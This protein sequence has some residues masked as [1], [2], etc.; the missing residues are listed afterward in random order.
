MITF[1]EIENILLIKRIALE[2]RKGL[3]VLT[4]ETGAGK[5][6]ILNC[7]LYLLGKKIKVNA[8]DL[9]RQGV[10][11]GTISACF[12]V[13]GNIPLKKF[14]VEKGFEDIKDEV[15]LKKIISS[16][17]KERSFLDTNVVSNALLSEIGNFLIE[18]N[19]QNEQV[20]LL[21]KSNHIRILDLYSKDTGLLLPLQTTFKELSSVR[22]KILEMEHLVLKFQ[23]E[24][25]YLESLVAE[26]ESLDI[27]ESEEADLSNKKL[28]I[29]RTLKETQSIH[30]IN[31]KLFTEKNI[32]SSL[33]SAA[34]ALNEID[35]CYEIIERILSELDL[36]EEAF[37]K[38]SRSTNFTEH[39]LDKINERLFLIRDVSRKY[40]IKPEELIEFLKNQKNI[41]EKINFSNQEIQSLR[42][43]EKSLAEKYKKHAHLLSLKRKESA[44]KLEKQINLEFRALEMNGADFKVSFKENSEK[45]T[46][47]GF[48]LIEFLVSTNEGVEH[49]SLTKI[50]SGGELSRLL[51]AIKTAMLEINMLETV[52]FD[53]IDSGIGGKTSI[54]VGMKLKELSRYTQVILITHQ[55]QIA[56]MADIHL[57]I[58]KNTVSAIPEIDIEKLSENRREEEIARMLSGEISTESINTAKKMLYQS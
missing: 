51:L 50:I 7:I 24:K 46:L 27:K 13:S 38:Y 28:E 17:G 29:S 40:R 5:S 35:E 42:E 11:K 39:D 52:I 26:I 48:D 32:R 22:A 4:G 58:Q 54:A 21:E 8:K 6:I 41:L 25:D 2:F 34:K 30:D 3:C 10:E 55:A 43:K 56:A 14:L 19:R 31:L 20:S 36:L 1:L 47:L 57:K 23:N 45:E 37:S 16:G 9:V 49:K 12:D 18:V 44:L 15:F 53:E 33:V